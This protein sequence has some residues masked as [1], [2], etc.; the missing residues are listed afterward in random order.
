[1]HGTEVFTKEKTVYGE[2]TSKI[3]PFEKKEIRLRKFRNTIIRF[4]GL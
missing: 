3:I 1:M 4:N 2:N